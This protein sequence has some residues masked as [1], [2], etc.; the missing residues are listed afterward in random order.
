LGRRSPGVFV[1]LSRGIAL[2]LPEEVEA[3][4]RTLGVDGF[5]SR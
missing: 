5:G 3:F 2:D 4:E 1:P